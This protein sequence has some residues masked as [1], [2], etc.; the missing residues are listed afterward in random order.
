MAKLLLKGGRIVDP[1]NGVDKKADLL[2]EDGKIRAIAED[3]TVPDAE[4]VDVAGKVVAPGLVDVHAH[5]RDPGFPEREDFRSGTMAAAAGGFTTVLAMPN[6]N[7]VC[8]NAVVVEYVLSKSRRE[9]VVN[10]LPIGAIT[11]GELGQE[12]VPMAE[13][14]AAGAVAFSDDGQPIMNAGVMRQALIM[15]KAVDKVLAVHCEDRNLTGEGVIA[16]GEVARRL[17]LKG[18]PYT[19]EAVMVARDILLAEETGAKLHICHVGCARS[20]ELIREGKRRGISVTA[21]VIPH[22][23]NTTD[24]DMVP[25]DGRFKIKPPFGSR[26]DMEALKEALADGT[27]EVVATDHAPYTAAEKSRDFRTQAPF[28]LVGFETALGV[29]LTEL[30][31]GKV[32]SLSAALA[33]MTCNPARIFGIDKGTLGVGKDADIVV[34]DLDREWVVDAR[35]YYSKSRNCP[36][37]GRVLKGKAVMTIV[38]GRIVMRDGKIVV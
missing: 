6:T 32:M 5:L 22:Y 37:D 3:L 36:Q 11:K 25:Y 1:A 13:L 4:T 33:A 8:D 27:I 35:T 20:V 30:V 19:S 12:V 15:G 10:V 34:I 18:I 21:E 23:L 24:E 9:G 26:R 38:G 7:P 29:V 28:G 2:I 31:H 14:V 16:E 17:G